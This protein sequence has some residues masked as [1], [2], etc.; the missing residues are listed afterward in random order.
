MFFL[1]RLTSVF[2]IAILSIILYCTVSGVCD[3]SLFT[4]RMLAPSWGFLC[5]LSGFSIL[6]LCQE[7]IFKSPVTGP[8]FQ[9]PFDYATRLVEIQKI[10]AES[11]ELP[12]RLQA[13]EGSIGNMIVQLSAVDLPSK[14]VLRS[15]FQG[16]WLINHWRK[17]LMPLLNEYRDVVDDTI[18]GLQDLL[19][20]ID[21]VVD[22]TIH[23]NR[24][25]SYEVSQI[26]ERDTSILHIFKSMTTSALGIRNNYTTEG[27]VVQTFL[28]SMT[29]TLKQLDGAL[30]NARFQRNKLRKLKAI[31]DDI[32]IT[33]LGD[34][35]KLEQEKLGQ[36]SYWKRI[37]H[38]HRRKL[39]DFDTQA[40]LCASFYRDTRQA[41]LVVSGAQL[42][43]QHIQG[44]LRQLRNKVE[45]AP[46]LLLSDGIPLQL[47]INT[48]NSDVERL[49]AT[50]TA[51][52]QLKNERVKT[53]ESLF[54]N[55]YGRRGLET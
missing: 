40:E 22:N 11:I 15:T 48:L 53:L 9:K 55:S 45:E 43:L 36:A 21:Q 54:K 6:P 47:Y 2:E 37:L 39:A 8:M 33:V 52:K 31:L 34:K 16:I 32:A 49:E 19:A 46:V 50:K 10:G 24:W 35:H 41:L 42:K 18:D 5:M 29:Q 3:F 23:I 30:I 14:Y 38:S 28:R 20:K 25:A 13:S 7:P 12:Y 4:A 51:T 27:A 26:A 1:S 44:E 17:H